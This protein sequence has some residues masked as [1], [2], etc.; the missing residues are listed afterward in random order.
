M[1]SREKSNVALRGQTI[2]PT[3]GS[4]SLFG[5][6]VFLILFP[7]WLPTGATVVEEA[8]VVTAVVK[9]VGVAVIEPEPVIIPLNECP[10]E[11]ALELKVDIPSVFISIGLKVVIVTAD[12]TPITFCCED[13]FMPDATAGEDIVFAEAV[14]GVTGPTSPAMCAGR[15]VRRE[16]LGE[17]ALP[18][19]CTLT[20]PPDFTLS[21]DEEDW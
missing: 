17:L 9:A 11:T 7:R 14:V 20:T 18:R 4:V 8:V 10:S 2:I 6:G 13:L 5:V 15:P 1:C 16:T 12:D 21:N 3:C 19:D